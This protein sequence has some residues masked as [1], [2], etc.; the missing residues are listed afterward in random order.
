MTGTVAVPERRVALAALLSVF[1]AASAC[2]T[3]A[4][5]DPTVIRADSA[6][7]PVVETLE[8]VWDDGDAWRVDPEPE[9]AIGLVEGDEVYLFGAI[10][11][12]G[13]LGDGQ[14][15]VADGQ[16]RRIRFYDETGRH[17]TT[18]GRPGDGPGE[19]GT[20]AELWSCGPGRIYAWDR[21][22]SRIS[23][24]SA[25][26]ELVRDFALLEPGAVGRGPYRAACGPGGG[27]VVAGWGDL[28]QLGDLAE[29]QFYAQSAPVWV[30]DADAQ[31]VLELGEYVI[32]E[33]ALLLRPGSFGGSSVSHPLGRFASFALDGEGIWVGTAERL[34]V[35]AYDRD[36]TLLRILRGPRQDLAL[37][38]ELWSRIREAAG[39][40][41]QAEARL[42]ARIEEL[43]LELPPGV[44]A[45][46]EMQ[47]DPEGRLWVRR[48]ALPWDEVERWGVFAREGE[49]LGHVEMPPGLRMH[50]VGADFVLGVAADAL[51]VE[52]V[53]LH[54]F[55][56]GD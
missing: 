36:G 23:E 20:L 16:I 18:A 2:D 29:S 28:S 52:Q 39:D 48:F 25:A 42:L 14:I 33:R 43:G 26:G 53:R 44:P 41:D 12:V 5:S 46:T 37:T 19:F 27:F 7:V 38:P 45:F 35:R 49:F 21:R 32:S 13:R 11:G 24:W 22:R 54:R 15:A 55:G 3:S 17:L 10:A 47:T 30:L 9:L 56:P 40:E 6:G 1:V 51:G 50:Q 31:P 8:P 34:E 4:R